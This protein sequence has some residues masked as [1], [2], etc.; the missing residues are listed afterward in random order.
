MAT[1]KKRIQSGA[2]FSPS[3]LFAQ[4]R[5]F[6]FLVVA[7]VVLLVTGVVADSVFGYPVFGGLIA[8]FALV[9]G[10]LVIS[11]GLAL[12]AYRVN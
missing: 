12:F 1:Q 4:F 6:V 3:D 2:S 8:A 7:N 9:S 11:V 5:W 10:G